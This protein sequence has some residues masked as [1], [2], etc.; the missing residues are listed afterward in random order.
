MASDNHPLTLMNMPLEVR[1]Q[2]FA[3]VSMSDT[4]PQKLLRY[5]FENK[6]VDE[7]IAAF[8]AR[9][10][11]ARVPMVVFD[12]DQYDDE[13]WEGDDDDQ[14]A[15]E[16]QEEEEDGG[17]DSDLDGEDDG[18]AEEDEEDEEEQVEEDFDDEAAG[19]DD[20]DEGN[21]DGDEMGDG[22]SDEE[23]DAYTATG[24]RPTGA[25]HPAPFH[26]DRPITAHSKWR[27]IPQ[28]RAEA[29]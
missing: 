23:G 28:V 15:E 26:M 14:E 24:A 17:G 12:G 22:E 20:D 10:L 1:H 16:E 25:M 27:H 21:E 8:K 13:D 2:I 6:E 3:Y 19:E 29:E 9:Y 7:K 18:D 4:Q 11:G 5:W